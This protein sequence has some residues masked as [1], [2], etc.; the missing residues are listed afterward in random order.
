M[1]HIIILMGGLSQRVI[2][3]ENTSLSR[4]S[5]YGVPQESKFGPLLFTSHIS[6]LEDELQDYN[7]N[8]IFYADDSQVYVS[9]NPNHPNDDALNTLRQS[10][11]LNTKN[12][13]KGNPEKTEVLLF[14]SGFMRQPSG[15]LSVIMDDNLSF[16][17][18]I[19][20]ICEKA[21][22]AMRSIRRIS[23]MMGLKC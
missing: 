17:A 11:S 4:C 19:N 23:R 20:E 3:G 8:C 6:P 14:T 12:M 21:T 18:H 22:L 9:I 1:G 10:V 13:S 7:L 5:E 2:I 15:D 16:S